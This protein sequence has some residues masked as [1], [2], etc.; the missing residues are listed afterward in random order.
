MYPY[1]FNACRIPAPDRDY[2]DT[3]AASNNH[4]LVVRHGQFFYFDVIDSDG[5]PLTTG[6]IE[7]QLQRIIS[8]AD[9]VS[10]PL[11]G[12]L[13]SDNRDTWAAMRTELIKCGNKQSLDILES[14]VLVV[15]LDTEAPSS[16][17]SAARVLWHGDGLNRWYDK[18]VHFIVCDNGQAGFLGEHSI[19]DGTP[20]LLMTHWCLDSLSRGSVSCDLSPPSRPLASPAH[21]VFRSS[22]DIERSITS[23]RST[24]SSTVQDH[25]LHVL[26]FRD[27]GKDRIK[28]LGVSPDAFAQLA[29]Q[30]AYYRMHGHLVGTYESCST[31]SFLHG[32][33]EVIRCCTPAAAAFVHSMQD[34]ATS[35]SAKHSAMLRAANAHIEYANAAAAG[36]GV[37]RHMLGMR[38]LRQPD[39]KVALFDDP[40]FGRSSKWRMSTSTLA[41]EYFDAW[42]FGEV[43][44][45]G[46]GVGYMVNNKQINATITSRNLGAHK[47]AEALRVS[48]LDMAAVCA[49]AAKP[50]QPQQHTSKL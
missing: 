20:T 13:T 27:F 4:I 39:Q 31:R 26:Q 22:P 19:M 33:T 29:L 6:E 32:R 46:F 37:D 45:D 42:G 50:A 10:G 7:A 40:V 48:L 47:F 8:L 34:T 41:S 16:V 11:V 9:T 21:I 28:Q 14:A 49:A 25:D 24:F 18:S 2:T 44:P 43:V 38:L 23:A 12:A 30:L 1:M 35:S 5:K 3:F 36:M 17:N 15:A